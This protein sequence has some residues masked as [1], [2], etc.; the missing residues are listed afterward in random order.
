MKISSGICA[1]RFIDEDR[2]PRRCAVQPR[3]MH[4]VRFS[5]FGVMDP[6]VCIGTCTNV[7]YIPFTVHVCQIALHIKS[8]GE[9]WWT[10]SI[11]Y[12]LDIVQNLAVGVVHGY[13]L[14]LIPVSRLRISSRIAG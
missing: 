12:L 8:C 7:E 6:Q 5:E 1:S 3:R 13:A 14:E 10:R 2:R 4:G 11:A 9:L